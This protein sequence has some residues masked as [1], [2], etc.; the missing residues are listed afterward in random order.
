[1]RGQSPPPAK[2]GHLGPCQPGGALG[3]NE[4]S[5]QHGCPAAHPDSRMTFDSSPRWYH[6]ASGSSAEPTQSVA[7]LR[8]WFRLRVA[9]QCKL[10]LRFPGSKRAYML[11]FN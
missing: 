9:G 6:S 5:N 8:P 1:M 4:N 11:E 7:V 2:L 10:M 3:A